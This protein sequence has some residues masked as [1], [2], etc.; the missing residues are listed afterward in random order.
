MQHKELSL[1]A[2]IDATVVRLHR[3]TALVT[4]TALVFCLFFETAK[5]GPFRAITLSWWARS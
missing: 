2:S 3:A 1:P 4:M 5:G